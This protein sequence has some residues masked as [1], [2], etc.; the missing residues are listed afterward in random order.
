MAKVFHRYAAVDAP[1]AEGPLRIAFSSETPVLRTGDGI[2]HKKGEKYWEILDHDRAN[3]NIDL[4]K[5]R[6][7]FL[8]EHDFKRPLGVI[9]SAEICDDKMGRA[10]VTFC[11]DSLSKD[12]STQ[13]RSKK[14]PHIS[15]G[16]VQSRCLEEKTGDDG[17]QVKRF[18]WQ[19]YEISSVAVPADATVGV[20]RSFDPAKLPSLK[21]RSLTLRVNDGSEMSYNDM[22]HQI[23]TAARGDERFM[24]KDN[25]NKLVGY[26]NVVDHKM[27]GK[28]ISSIIYCSVDGKYH[29]VE[30]HVKEGKIELGHDKKVKAKTNWE[31]EEEPEKDRSVDLP[32]LTRADDVLKSAESLPESEKKILRTKLMAETI[33]I[34][35]PTVRADEA[36]KTRATVLSEFNATGEKLKTR[37]AEVRALADEYVKDHGMKWNG[38]QGKVFV[39]GERIRAFG[40]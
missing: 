29:E 2:D 10:D 11:D 38:P 7:S 8:D 33:T 19:A 1:A 15:F 9:E 20:G 12:R 3:A 17:V 35:E 30:V 39:V 6:G 37:N 31:P 32:K 22:T 21:T 14:R 24:G 18:A 36:R 23:E 27:A 40:V 5:D 16:Y 28:S 34:D 25:N 13:L 4:L 26:V